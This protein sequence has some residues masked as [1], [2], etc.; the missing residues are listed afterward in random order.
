LAAR[1]FRPPVA[2][3]VRP[4]VF[5][6]D[7]DAAVRESLE[8]LV[9]REGWRCETFATAE[10][11]LRRAPADAPNCLVADVSLANTDALDL[12]KRV[13]SERP[14]T[15]IIFIAARFDVATTVKAIKAGAVEFFLKPLS[16]SPLLT[17]IKEGF[18]SSR[19]H[20]AHDGERRALGERYHDLSRR[21]REVMALVVSGLLNKQVG[22]ELG[23][24]ER[25]VKAHRGQVMQKMKA[26]SLAHLVKM[27]AKLG[28]AAG[29]S[30]QMLTAGTEWGFL[31][32]AAAV[33]AVV[34]TDR[35]VA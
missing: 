14:G 18:E 2:P 20:I 24:S 29:R 6:L 9:R 11:F 4:I 22:G 21:E 35:R 5:V 30:D 12:Q 17:S 15:S 19:I 31:L 33:P 23:I 34:S 3:D 8:R 32:S 26:D 25:T 16:E 1:G 10:E 27:A 28:V 7:E 13:A